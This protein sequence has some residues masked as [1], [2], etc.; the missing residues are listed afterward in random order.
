M[1]NF[2]EIN[3]CVDK[4]CTTYTEICIDFSPVSGFTSTTS[5]SIKIS[6]RTRCCFRLIWRPSSISKTSNER[7]WTIR[8]QNVSIPTLL[9]TMHTWTRQ[10]RGKFTVKYWNNW[11]LRYTILSYIITVLGFKVILV[12]SWMNWPI[13][14]VTCVAVFRATWSALTVSKSS[15]LVKGESIFV[16]IRLFYSDRKWF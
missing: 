10:T 1:K 3:F 5:Q 8:I 16:L 13:P 4:A 12:A 7:I 14:C 6:N 15:P 11:Q 9:M 2:C